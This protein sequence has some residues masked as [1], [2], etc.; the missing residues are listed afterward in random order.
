MLVIVVVHRLYRC[1][2]LLI[3]F[4]PWQFTNYCW[5]LC[6]LVLRD[7]PSSLLLSGPVSK[8]YGVFSNSI[9]P[10]KTMIIPYVVLGEF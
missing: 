4:L 6:E 9:L 7:E 1:V 3:A 8:V 10:S 2:G 5:L